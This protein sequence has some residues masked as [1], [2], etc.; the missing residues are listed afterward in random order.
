M[1]AKKKPAKHDKTE[2]NINDFPVDLMAVLRSCPISKRPSWKEKY[3]AAA[4]GHVWMDLEIEIAPE[5]IIPQGFVFQSWLRQRPIPSPNRNTSFFGEGTAG[6]V[7]SFIRDKHRGAVLGLVGD[8]CSNDHEFGIAIVLGKLDFLFA[9]T[10]L[11]ASGIS[12]RPNLI[13]EI[14]VTQTMENE[15][16]SDGRLSLTACVREGNAL[17]RLVGTVDANG[18]AA[19]GHGFNGVFTR[20]VGVVADDK[21]EGDASLYVGR[22]SLS[23]RSQ[24]QD[25]QSEKDR[26]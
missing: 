25:C 26:A 20:S 7:P 5:E 10:E 11:A 19:L 22:L 17:L 24:E 23:G 1:E 21:V 15:G 9:H 6:Y 2:R 4:K 13:E 12:L 18:G 3:D 14:I 8:V 16:R